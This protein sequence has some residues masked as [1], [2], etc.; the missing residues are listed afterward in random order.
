MVLATPVSIPFSCIIQLPNHLP[1]LMKASIPAL[2]LMTK[3]SCKRCTL[4]S[5][6]TNT[7][8][9]KAIRNAYVTLVNSNGLQAV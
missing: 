2:C 4:V 8:V 9:C 6:P 1:P 3:R 7:Q 5:I